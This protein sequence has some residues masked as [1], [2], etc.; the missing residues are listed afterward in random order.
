MAFGGRLKLTR[1]AAAQLTVAFFIASAAVGLPLAWNRNVRLRAAERRE[2]AAAA[3]AAEAAAAA[4]ADEAP[5]EATRAAERFAVE[6]LVNERRAARG[7]AGVDY[8]ARAAAAARAALGAE[9]AADNDALFA[10]LAALHREQRRREA[11][12]AATMAAEAEA[13]AAP[14]AALSR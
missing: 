10:R 8:P 6:L 7:L 13:A 2:G 5:D 4:A 12:A 3:A 9:G 11:A 1:A 14:E